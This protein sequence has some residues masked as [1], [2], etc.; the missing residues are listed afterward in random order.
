MNTAYQPLTAEASQRLS[1]ERND[2]LS[3]VFMNEK[4]LEDD[5]GINEENVVV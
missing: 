4:A 3:D 5:E 2:L 1:L